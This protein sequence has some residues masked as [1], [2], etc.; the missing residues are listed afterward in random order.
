MVLSK[1]VR[2]ILATYC[3]FAAE[4]RQSLEGQPVFKNAM[5]VF[6][7]ERAK[8]CREY[9]LKFRVW[10]KDKIEIPPEIL[11]TREFYQSM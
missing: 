3:P 7:R 9:D 6:Q 11:A 2:E 1:P 4:I 5:A 8:K 10:E